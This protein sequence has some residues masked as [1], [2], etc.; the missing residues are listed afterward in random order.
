MIVVEITGAGEFLRGL[1]R[2]GDLMDR[3]ETESETFAADTTVSGARPTV[4]VIS[5]DAAGS[6]RTEDY[7]DGKA[8]VGGSSA[9]LYYGWLEFG[10]DAGR[11]HS[12]H[13]DEVPDGRYLHPAYMEAFDKIERKMADSLEDAIRDAGLK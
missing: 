3:V 1:N 2:L 6:L 8:A 12:V 4:P 7:S 11:G 9:V 13:R 10:G 5:G